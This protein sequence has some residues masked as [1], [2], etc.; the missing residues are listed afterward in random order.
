MIDTVTLDLRE[1]L[2]M[3]EKANA[4]DEMDRNPDTYIVF[5]VTNHWNLGI[6]TVFHGAKKDVIDGFMKAIKEQGVV[7]L[8]LESEIKYLRDQNFALRNKKPW[9]QFW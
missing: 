4:I 8:N 5:H 3:R 9:Y 2:L 6:S 1:Y 7:I